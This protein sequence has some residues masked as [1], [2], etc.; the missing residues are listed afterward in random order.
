MMKTYGLIVIGTGSA[1]NNVQPHLESRPEAKIA[2]I[3]KG[4]RCHWSP[5]LGSD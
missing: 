3:D 1:M 2:V 5:V 4:A